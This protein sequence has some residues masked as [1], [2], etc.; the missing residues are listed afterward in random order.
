MCGIGAQIQHHNPHGPSGAAGHDKDH[1]NIHTP[2]RVFEGLRRTAGIDL[3]WLHLVQP[4]KKLVAG[5][6]TVRECSKIT[7]F[8]VERSANMTR[9]QFYF[10]CTSLDCIRR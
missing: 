9:V 6:S 2:S 10:R 1:N 3:Q 7:M 8:V 4:A 5:L